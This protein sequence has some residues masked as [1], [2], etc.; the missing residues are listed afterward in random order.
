MFRSDQLAW[1]QA[2]I[3][4]AWIDGGTDYVG[5]PAGWGETKRAEYRARTYHHPTDEVRADFDYSGLVQLAEITAALVQQIGAGGTSAWKS[6]P[7]LV[8]MKRPGA[9]R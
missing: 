8:G 9:A 1:A 3:P 2:G 6:D 4:A 5:R 7:E